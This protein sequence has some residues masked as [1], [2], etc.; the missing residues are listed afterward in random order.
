MPE[1]PWLQPTMFRI[2]AGEPCD[3]T[4]LRRWH[5]TVK[6]RERDCVETPLVVSLPFAQ[7]ALDRAE[8]VCVRAVR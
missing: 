4:D 3:P 8:V 1:V 7:V 6:R 2:M 5:L